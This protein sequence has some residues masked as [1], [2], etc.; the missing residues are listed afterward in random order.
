VAPSLD[1]LQL[2]ADAQPI[3]QHS[4]YVA[5]R[6]KV[7]GFKGAVNSRSRFKEA[8]SRGGRA[9][10]HKPKSALLL[11]FVDVLSAHDLRHTSPLAGPSGDTA[12][13]YNTSDAR[14]RAEESRSHV[15]EANS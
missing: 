1:S 10:I 7:G 3:T 13:M 2:R 9:H 15:R 4:S 12:I 6:V 14:V 5:R 11:R 8:D